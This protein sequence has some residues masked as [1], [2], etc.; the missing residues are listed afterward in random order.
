MGTKTIETYDGKGNLVETA[1]VQTTPEQDNQETANARIDQALDGLRTYVAL[2]S[3][4][5]AQTA[6]TVKLLCRV[7][8]NVVRLMRARFDAVD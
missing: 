8:L 6:A 1:S 4:T 7:V 2:P 5:A 3:P